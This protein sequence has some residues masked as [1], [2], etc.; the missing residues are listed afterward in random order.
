MSDTPD[1]R[2]YLVEPDSWEALI[3]RDSEKLHCYQKNPGED[4]FHR[5]SKGE[6]YLQS[7]TEKLCL[8]CALRRGVATQDRLF[9]QNRVPRKPPPIE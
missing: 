7:E 1:I 3:K 5:I 8:T 6:V 4:F 2:L 9:W